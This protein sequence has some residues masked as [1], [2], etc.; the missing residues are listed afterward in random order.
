MTLPS[1]S[2]LGLGLGLGLV[3]GLALPLTLTRPLATLGAYTSH[4]LK[5]GRIRHGPLFLYWRC[6]PPPH[7][8]S[9]DVAATQDYDTRRKLTSRE[10]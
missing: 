1:E 5:T 10:G 2:G 4:P 3:L 6:A 7:T 9:S 8:A